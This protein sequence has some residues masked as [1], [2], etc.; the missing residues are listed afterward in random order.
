MARAHRYE[1]LPHAHALGAMEPS[2]AA[3]HTS[4]CPE[5]HG[6]PRMESVRQEQVGDA[7]DHRSR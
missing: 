4:G 7:H 2:T 5:F 6:V 1:T 3:S